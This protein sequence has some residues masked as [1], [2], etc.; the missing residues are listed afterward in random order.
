MN[1]LLFP[2]RLVFAL[3]LTPVRVVRMPMKIFGLRGTVALGIGVGIG[4][5]VAP[6]PGSETRRALRDWYDE[7]QG[8]RAVGSWDGPGS[9]GTTSR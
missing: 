9:L 1:L 5:L 2:F 6:R 4:M 7:M 3:L 8:Q